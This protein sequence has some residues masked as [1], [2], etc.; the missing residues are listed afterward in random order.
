[1]NWRNFYPNTFTGKYYK[2]KKTLKEIIQNIDLFKGDFDLDKIYRIIE[3]GLSA[4]GINFSIMMLDN[5]R[6]VLIY[7][8]YSNQKK[9]DIKTP[10]LGSI[11]LSLGEVKHYQKVINEKKSNWSDKRIEYIQNNFSGIANE[12]Y[13][14]K[15]KKLKS[16]LSP[17]I[18]KN[19][20]IGLVDFYSIDLNENLLGL[21]ENF[22]KNLTRTLANVILYEENRRSEEKYRMLVDNAKDGV[23]IINPNGNISFAN[24]ALCEITGYVRSELSKLHISELIYEED[25]KL[26]LSRFR[27]RM[28]GV[29]I[30]NTYEFRIRNKKGQIVY[31][32]YSGTPIKRGKKIIGIQ[33]V[34]RD[35]T[36]NKKFDKK[37][38][39]AK[40][41]Y[42]QIIDT[43]NDGLCVISRE[44]KITSCNRAFAKNVN[45]PIREILGKKCREIIPLYEK[46]ILAKHC[47]HSVCDKSCGTDEVFLKG[48]TKIFTEVSTD[49]NGRNQ[50]HYISVFPTIDADGSINQVV[51]TIRNIT[52]R[53]EAEEK[54]R[55]LSEFNQRILDASPIS[56]LAMDKKGKVV[57][58]NSLARSLMNR[59]KEEIVGRNLL[60]IEHIVNNP[61][62]IRY[63]ENL[64]KKGKSFFYNDMAYRPQKQ[65]DQER[66]LNI[67]AVPLFDKKGRVEG[68]ISMALDNTEAKNAKDKLEELNKGLETIVVKR[69]QELDDINKKLSQAIKLKSKFI[70][71]ASHELRTPLTVIQGNLDLAIRE[72]VKNGS[73]HSESLPLILSEVERMTSILS[74]L[75]MLT[76]ADSR[77]EQILHEEVDLGQLVR[78]VGQSLKVLADQKKIALIYK[79]GAKRVK[80]FGDEAKL[81]KLLLNIVRNAI[82]YSRNKGR[83]K[84]WVENNEQQGKI[85][86][87]DNGIGI[88]KED[89]SYI[90]ERFYRVDKSRSREEGGTGL[91]LSI[92]K[93]IAELHGGNI[94]VE[95]EFGKGSKFT[96]NLPY[97]YKSRPLI[98][99]M[100]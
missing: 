29:D 90:F 26:I 82:K 25:K 85:F 58:A 56:I 100:L 63:Y 1:M 65:K 18:I 83:I 24:N 17:I 64:F 13:G 67:I 16:I 94:A 45:M 20:V 75:T 15:G 87:E 93:W 61:Q 19:E 59:P 49:I 2:H 62:L 95:S 80:I 98:K 44:F 41:R 35:I 54:I 88:P 60:K 91:G 42:E 71:D 31:L 46:N 5:Q 39:Q 50:Y 66:S 48:K 32:S 51:M 23:A 96:I 72:A 21:F 12:I 55:Q 30:P 14:A 47:V 28:K 74:D 8:F 92:C 53:M 76:N 84:I 33:S 10:G 57:A 37:I 78:S 79:K 86:V 52:E 70:A 4:N 40:D 38:K 34:I 7:R 97:D 36:E 77:T 81:E 68:A 11:N 43:I 9:T 99:S 89:L 69:T 3:N 22:S 27:D 73:E 6:D